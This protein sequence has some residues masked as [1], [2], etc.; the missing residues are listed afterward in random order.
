[1]EK[2]TEIIPGGNGLLSKDQKDM[3]VIFGPRIMKK[4]ELVD[5]SEING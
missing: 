3:Q 4:Q 1:M 2:I 5:L